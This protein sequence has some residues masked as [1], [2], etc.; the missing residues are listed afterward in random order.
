MLKNYKPKFHCQ[1]Q[2]VNV[3]LSY[4]ESRGNRSRISLMMGW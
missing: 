2:I 1:I 4:H 3:C